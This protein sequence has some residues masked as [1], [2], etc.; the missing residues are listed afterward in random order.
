[1]GKNEARSDESP[2]IVEQLFD[3]PVAA[4]WDAITKLEKMK[5]WFFPN[6]PAF[7]PFV[8]FQVDFPVQSN[9]RTFTHLWKIIEVVPHSRIKYY[10]T[11]REYPG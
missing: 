7:E 9:N 11:Y 10:W 1:M 2:I 8:G 5:Q 6:I 4:V 3:S